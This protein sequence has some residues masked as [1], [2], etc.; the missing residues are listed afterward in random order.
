MSKFD[1][2]VII[3]TYNN[4]KWLEKVLWSYKFQSF[5]NFEILVADDG[6]SKET[7]D[8]IEVFKAKKF[9]SIKHVWHEDNGFRK[10]KI[11]NKAILESSSEYL[12]FTDGD[13]IARDDFIQ[14]HIDNRGRGVFLSGGYFKLPQNISNIISKIDIKSKNCFDLKWLRRNGL[15]Y[16]IKNLKLKARGCFTVLLNNLTTTKPTW[17]GHNSSGWKSDILNV[18]GFDERMQYGGEDRELG[19][20]MANNGII[21][22]QIRYSAIC[23]H[24]YHDRGY[25]KDEMIEFN[26]N[27]RRITRKYNIKKT[28]F[29]IKN[30]INSR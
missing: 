21:P 28:P 1:I 17:N 25:V 10:T 5:R 12:L 19:E 8:L 15:K 24:L 3:S 22:K 4:P 7:K 18:N 6:S 26:K 20:R 30:S 29:G 9:F 14:Q 2:S 11:L 23:I 13:C 27:V 16:S